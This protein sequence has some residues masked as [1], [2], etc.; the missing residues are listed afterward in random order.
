MKGVGGDAA[1]SGNGAGSYDVRGMIWHV[2]YGNPE[3]QDQ[4]GWMIFNAIF[5]VRFSS[6]SP[7][8]RSKLTSLS[9]ISSCTLQW[10]NTGNY[11]T[12]LGYIAYWL[13]IAA[14]LVYLKW[15]EGRM[16]LFGFKSK[17]LKEREARGSLTAPQDEKRPELASRGSDLTKKNSNEGSDSAGSS[18]EDAHD[19]VAT[20]G[21]PVRA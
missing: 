8:S 13:V 2:D 6:L 14:T 9:L 10:N 1:E 5:G 20:L 12:V 11:G 17:A 19:F 4:G 3:L 15:Q 7:S 18:G 21:A 16:T